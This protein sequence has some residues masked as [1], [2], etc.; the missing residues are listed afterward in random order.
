M[1][2]HTRDA[3]FTGKQAIWNRLPQLFVLAV[4]NCLIHEE[5]PTFKLT[6][7]TKKFGMRII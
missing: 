3:M 2:K 1:V 4:F 5:T 6:I 7:G